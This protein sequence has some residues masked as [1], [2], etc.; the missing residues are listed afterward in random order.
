MCPLAEGER[1]AQFCHTY[2]VLRPTYSC[3]CFSPHELVAMSSESAEG[4]LQSVTE[5]SFRVAELTVPTN[6][7]SISLERGF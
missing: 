3:S 7:S 1:A 6:V 2:G 4:S 5:D